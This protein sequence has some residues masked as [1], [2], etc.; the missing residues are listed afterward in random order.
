[1]IANWGHRAEVEDTAIANVRFASGAFCNVQLSTCDR[2]LNYRQISGDR[3]TVVYQDEKNANSLVPDVFRLGRY[4]A[5]MR[6]FISG[7]DGAVAG[8]PGV[9]WEDV[10]VPSRGEGPTLV[11]SFVSAILDG[12]EAITDGVTARR[13]LELINAIVFSAVRKEVVSLPLDR[14]RYD[15]LMEELRSGKRAV[16]RNPR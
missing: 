13:T 1:M 2:R 10:P 12:G 6:D 5:P 7:R 3:G 11:E 4:E 14:G 16:F 15:E 8:Q 9:T